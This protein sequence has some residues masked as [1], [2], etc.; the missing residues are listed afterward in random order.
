MNDRS[1]D[2]VI[3]NYYQ[4]AY[5]EDNRL[6]KDKAHF[7]EFITT[8]TY[9]D[10]YLKNNDRILEVGAGTG[11]YSLFYANKGYQVDAL[12]LVQANVD[13]I[14]SR[15][16]SN[17]NISAI[18]G[19]ALDLSMYEDNTF[20]ITLVL[21]PLYHLFKDE[22]VNKAIAEAIRVTKKNGIIYFAFC[23]FD[24]TMI[25]WGFQ[26]KNIYNNYGEG[27]QVTPD[28]KPVNEE[29]L[30]FNLR[31]YEDVKKLIEKFNVE[32]LHYVATDGVG[33]VIKDT[34]N[35]M[36]EEEY[37]LYVNYHLST[38]EREDLIGYSGHI[39]S[40]VRKK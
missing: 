4:N 16:T 18:Q 22:E 2:N 39:L 26:G 27:K 12:E 36:S 35:N 23:L 1:L 32:E 8:T 6:I 3:N 31:Y 14:K 17:I 13:V 34:I 24:S 19:N 7:F 15:I 11:A 20:D 29:E 9:I 28:F 21:G 30:I 38:C 10:K 5:E 40:I 37:Q 25:T 33:R